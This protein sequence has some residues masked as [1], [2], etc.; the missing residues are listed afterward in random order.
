[1]YVFFVVLMLPFC[2][3]STGAPKK[4][5]QAAQDHR[6]KTIKNPASTGQKEMTSGG[7]EPP[8][9]R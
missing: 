5:K 2:C 4:G 3:R 8:T 9:F 7:V 6:A 1:L